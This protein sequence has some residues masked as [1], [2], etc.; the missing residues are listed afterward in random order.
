MKTIPVCL[1]KLKDVVTK[2]V[3]K[4]AVCNKL[5]AKVN[6]LESRIPDAT[7]LIHLN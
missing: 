7:T 1:K 2:E 3:F 4:K 5:N 6:N